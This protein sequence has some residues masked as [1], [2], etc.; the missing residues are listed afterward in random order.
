[1]FSE[2]IVW[3]RERAGRQEPFFCYLPLNA[4]HS[5][6]FVPDRF[7]EPYRDQKPAVA[8]F[9]GM[10]ANIDENIGKLARKTERDVEFGACNK[11]P[12]LPKHPG[13]ALLHAS[14]I[15]A[16]VA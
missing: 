11:P 13:I 14:L 15:R 10:I 7:R 4:P 5:P 12:F 9:F 6:L 2:A 16:P 3:M 1:M 8:G